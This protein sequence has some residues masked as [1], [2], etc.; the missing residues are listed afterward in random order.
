MWKRAAITTPIQ[1]RRRHRELVGDY[2]QVRARQPD[3]RDPQVRED[4]AQSP[5]QLQRTH[6]KPHPSVGGH[7]QDE[8]HDNDRYG[9]CNHPARQHPGGETGDPEHPDDCEQRPEP[10][11]HLAAVLFLPALPDPEQ[12]TQYYVRRPERDGEDQERH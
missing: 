8:T 6:Q 3:G 7:D 9:G 1:K 4:V 12:Q 5:D 10:L 11:G 2:R